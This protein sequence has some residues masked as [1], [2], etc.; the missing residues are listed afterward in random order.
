[1]YATEKGHGKYC[2]R[3]CQNEAI[4]EGLKKR[5]EKE[6]PV[7]GRI[8]EARNWAIQNGY[9]I[10]C[11]K[12]CSSIA[13]TGEKN[14]NWQGGI[15]FEPYCPKFNKMFKERVR[16]YF[17]RKCV[18]CGK[19]ETENKRKLSVHHVFH[20]KEACCD[21]SLPYF[22]TLCAS[23]HGRVHGKGELFQAYFE[24]LINNKYG[25]ECYY[26]KEEW[27]EIDFSH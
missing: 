1:M 3:Q 14:Y 24:N 7:C 19:T 26:T 11:S 4:A 8:F 6:C 12:K 25:G 20:N 5:I 18:T 17:N 21:D 2:S 16:D 27:I 13:I 23:C 22:V 15:S 10:Y 9:G